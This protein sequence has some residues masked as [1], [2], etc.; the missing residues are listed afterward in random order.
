MQYLIEV[1]PEKIKVFETLL[2]AW[3]EAGVVEDFEE[4]EP[5]DAKSLVMEIPTSY[6]DF[7]KQ[8]ESTVSAQDM[9]E[10]YRDLVD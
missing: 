2:K 1:Q 9:V 7:E 8:P 3:Q 10:Q 6:T 5:L 4:I